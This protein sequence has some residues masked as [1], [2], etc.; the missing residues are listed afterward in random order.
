MLDKDNDGKVNPDDLVE[1]FKPVMIKDL[2]DADVNEIANQTVKFADQDG[3]N[4]LNFDEFKM[5]YNNLLKIT[6]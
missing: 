4:A 2:N 6:I 5:F 3:D 1:G